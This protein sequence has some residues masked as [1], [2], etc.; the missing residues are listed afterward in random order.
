MLSEAAVEA[1]DWMGQVAEV[2]VNDLGKGEGKTRADGSK[3]CWLIAES[4]L[5]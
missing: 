4:E 5:A 1:V 2:S 3:S